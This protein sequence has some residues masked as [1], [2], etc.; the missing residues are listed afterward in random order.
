MTK[1]G[2]RLLRVDRYDNL[3]AG[4]GKLQPWE[5]ARLVKI[6]KNQTALGRLQDINQ[7]RG[8]LYSSKKRRLADSTK[9]RSADSALKD[10]MLHGKQAGVEYD[11]QSPKKRRDQIKAIKALR[12]LGVE[13][14]SPDDG[15][16]YVKSN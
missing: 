7:E 1:Q 16:I 11:S 5:K 2:G 9:K 10:W 6:T 3:K 14:E 13:Y 12:F 4:T 8:A 15:D